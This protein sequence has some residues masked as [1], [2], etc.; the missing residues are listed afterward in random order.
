MQ[1]VSVPLGIKDPAAPN[2]AS[3]FWRTVSDSKNRIVVFDSATSPN[4]FWVTLGDL[5]LREGAP[6]RKLP[7]AGGRTYNGNAASKFLPAEPF[8]FLGSAARK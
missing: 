4:A 1:S 5:D 7:L 3:T 2:I 6:I 8:K